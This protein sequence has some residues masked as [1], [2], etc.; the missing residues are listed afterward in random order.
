MQISSSFEDLCDQN[1]IVYL[2]RVKAKEYMSRVCRILSPPLSTLSAACDQRPVR[3]VGFHVQ[4]SLPTGP[5]FAPADAVGGW[6][7]LHELL[8]QGES[9]FPSC[10]LDDC[11]CEAFLRTLVQSNR[12]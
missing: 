5:S 10:D 6:S 12:R 4:S 1:V 7:L 9:I 2:L 3:S 8:V 11:V